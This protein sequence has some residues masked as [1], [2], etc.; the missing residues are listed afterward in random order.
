[1]YVQSNFKSHEYK[2][3][4]SATTTVFGPAKL[5]DILRIAIRVKR[6]HRQIARAFPNRSRDRQSN[7]KAIV[8][9]SKQFTLWPKLAVYC[10]VMVTAKIA[11]RW[12]AGRKGYRWLRDESTRMRPPDRLSVPS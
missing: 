2:T 5:R 12:P 4:A 11:A 3:V 9:L 1:M 6:G 7:N 8:A 10:S